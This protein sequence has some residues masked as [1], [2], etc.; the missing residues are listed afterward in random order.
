MDSRRPVPITAAAVLLLVV[1]A[2][3]II[4][5]G[6]I[7]GM[8]LGLPTVSPFVEVW[9][10]AGGLFFGASFLGYQLIRTGR[11]LLEG[12]LRL[13]GFT[14]SVLLGCG[15]VAT[16]GSGMASLAGVALLIAFDSPLHSV[17]TVLGVVLFALLNSISLL[18]SG[19][20]LNDNCDR[21]LKWQR[22]SV[23]RSREIEVGE[24]AES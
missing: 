6:V 13:S 16:I 12:R 10:L 19:V 23:T 2:N 9:L 17:G 5:G 8:I 24:E 1:G 11:H 3:V 4:A 14:V 7:A 20:M 18:S 15:V 21:Y 22:A